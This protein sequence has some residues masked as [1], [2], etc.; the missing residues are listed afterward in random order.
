MV[1]N[2]VRNRII[3]SQILSHYGLAE[4]L[5]NHFEFSTFNSENAI[6]IIYIPISDKGRAEMNIKFSIQIV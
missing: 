4:S 6:F 3:T 5:T 1:I 2:I